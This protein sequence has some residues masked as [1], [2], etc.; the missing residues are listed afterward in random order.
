MSERD[1][2]GL[3]TGTEISAA[4]ATVGAP[5]L[6]DED[7]RVRRTEVAISLVLRIGVV[8]SLLVVVAGVIDGMV[9]SP[10]ERTS[11]T[12]GHSLISRGATFPHSFGSLFTGLGHGDPASIVAAGLLL[13]VLT[14]VLRVAVS[15]LTFA[16]QRD[17]VFVVVTAF[18]LAVLIASFFL[19]TAGG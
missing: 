12:L 7:E 6:P 2:G 18:V 17:A 13:L 8:V 16:Y 19:G 14:P 3:V 15:I 11:A 10:A 9:R 4:L 5:S 1:E